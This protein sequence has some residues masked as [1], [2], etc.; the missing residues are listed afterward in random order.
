MPLSVP[1]A[2]LTFVPSFT[3]S[4]A[5][6]F[7]LKSMRLPRIVSNAG[8]P[9]A[10]KTAETKVLDTQVLNWI[11]SITLQATTLS[12]VRMCLDDEKCRAT[13]SKKYS[14]WSRIRIFTSVNP[15]KPA[16]IFQYSAPL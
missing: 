13:H 2:T 7:R 8:F 3:P 6:S 9:R 16:E 10:F 14:A 15:L 5:A 1:D 11:I 4:S 12:E